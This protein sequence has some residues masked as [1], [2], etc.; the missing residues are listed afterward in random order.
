MSAVKIRG[1][2][3]VHSN[4]MIPMRDGIRLAADI[5]LPAG[6]GDADP[7]PFPVLLERT[8][9]D[10][11]GPRDNER[12]AADARPKLRADVASYFA[13]HGYAVVIQDCRGRYASEGVFTKYIGEAE[14][15]FDTMAWIAEQDWCGGRIGTFGLSYAGHTQTA[16]AALRPPGLTAMLI[17]SGGFSN[18]YRGGIR[19]GGAFELK[20]ATWAFKHARL[21]PAAMDD[22]IIRQALDAEDIRTWFDALPWRR[23]HSPL[24][25]VP[26]YEDYFFDQWER[27]SFDD[28]WRQPELYAAGNYDAFDGIPVLLLCG[29]YD[30]YVQTTFDNLSGIA[31]R[32]QGVA[33]AVLGPWTHG[34]RSVPHAGGVA[35]G[36]EATLDGNLASDYLDF[37]RAWFDRWLK[38]D[39]E[40]NSGTD[41]VP[42][43]RYFRMGGGDGTRTPEGRLN[44][45]GT[46]RTAAGW[47][48][49]GTEF[50]TFHL[51]SDG[52]LTEQPPIEDKAA[53][54]YDFD[55][56]NPVPTIGGPI[57]S[58]LP[59]AV[60]GAFDQRTSPDI[61]GA[62]PPFLPLEARSDILVFETDPLEAD[63][64]VTGPITVRLWISSDGPDTDFT[65]KL[66]DH[67]PPS[68][69]YPQGFSM[70]LS[71]GI[72]RCRYR[73]SWEVPEMLTP[74][75]IAEIVIEPMP[76]SNLFRR[77]HRIRVDI[78]SS[79]FPRF[80]V[81]PNTGEP[82]GRVRLS[83]IAVN[84]VFMDRDHPSHII[85]PVVR[86]GD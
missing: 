78:S 4:V 56:A 49:P 75:E 76:T 71:D 19:N 9:Y 20:Q 65:V 22:P 60:P 67:H 6:T 14:D 46:W 25:W 11:T 51:R 57:T 21:S 74:G 28:Y 72:L 12:T 64:E 10:K 85:L 18:A 30:P 55:P 53:L 26:E 8:P 38:P 48:I 80:D 45:G 37:R 83:R 54:S 61:Y 29:W 40:G 34:Q 70:N 24:R 86:R 31:H 52:V 41:A 59:L 7:G 1:D 13:R 77:G 36:P 23:G 82:E 3:A 47:P 17:D 84:T 62:R 63:M 2:V 5:Y 35:F 27:G 69:D 16:M 15:G 39:G 50:R 33:H 81:N 32:P 73:N 43:V 42:F 58:L 79:N 68:S 44:Q 66:I